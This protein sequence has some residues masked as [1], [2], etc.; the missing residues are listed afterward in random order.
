MTDNDHMAGNGPDRRN[1]FVI[2]GRNDT[3]RSALFEFLRAVG[4][5]PI[6]WSQAIKMT[7]QGSP[8]IGDVLDAAFSGAQAIVVL[9]TP[10]DVVYLNPS[11]TH[12]ADPE[13]DPQPQPR[14][15]VLFEA[16]MA[17]GRNPERVIIVEL[18][19]VKS[20]SD[21]HGRHVVRLDNSLRKRLDLVDRLETA[22]CAVDRSGRDWQS[23][24]DLT[25]PANKDLRRRN[26]DLE[27][28]VK[29]NVVLI[30]PR[31][32]EAPT[33]MFVDEDGLAHTI[34]DQL[35][36]DILGPPVGLPANQIEI[37]SHGQP[38][39]PIG[40]DSFRRRNMDF[41][42]IVDKWLVYLHT[43]APVYRFWDDAAAVPELSP[44]ESEMLRV[45]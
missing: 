31:R 30:V 40:K 10:D 7:K 16:G 17:M 37:L 18:G 41:F 45:R 27:N 44:A 23:A 4:L 15:N 26:S 2:H 12:A 21:I 39:S 38:I 13:C 3:A 34:T 35:T 42:V 33:Y 20:F 14:P 24:G 32:G 11:L 6:V 8:Y 22:G 29:L 1:V 19:Q 5:H 28:T 36:A 25:P 9:Q 43:L